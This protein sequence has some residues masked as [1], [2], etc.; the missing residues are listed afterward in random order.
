LLESEDY[1][2][3]IVGRSEAMQNVFKLVGQLASSDALHSSPAKAAPARNW[4]ARRFYHHSRPRSATV[5]RGQ[6]RH[7]G[8]LLESEL[9][10]TKKAHSLRHGTPHRQVRAMRQRTI[11]LDEIGDMSLPRKR[12]FALL[13]SGVFQRVGGNQPIQVNVRVIAATNK[14]LEQWSPRSSSAKI[15]LSAERGAHPIPPLRERGRYPPVDK[16]FSEKIA[17]EQEQRPSPSRW[18]RQIA[19][20]IPVAGNVREL[21]NVIQRAIVVAKVMRSCWTICHGDFRQPGSRRHPR[22]PAA[23][24]RQAPRSSRTM[25]L[26]CWRA[27][28]SNWPA[29]TTN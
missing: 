15:C 3:G 18:K 22:R 23:L 11:F 17:E 5:P 6:L 14:P 26:P 8:D 20:A 25:D 9:F 29:R 7:T 16:L 13:Q 28:C 12:R 2:L 21:E 27:R 10:G 4:W 1:D 24:R 19:R